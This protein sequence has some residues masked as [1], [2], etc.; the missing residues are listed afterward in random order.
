[1]AIHIQEE[2]ILIPDLQNIEHENLEEKLVLILKSNAKALRRLIASCEKAKRDLSVITQ[3]IVD[4]DALMD[5]EELNVV[6][7]RSK[8]QDLCMDLFKKYIP[9]ENVIKDSKISKNQIDK[10][11]LLIGSTLVPKIQKMAQEF[12]KEKNK[13]KY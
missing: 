1:M 9:L 10:V 4:I 5:G 8:F 13:K 11:V 7:A 6:I 12:F 3:Y 2:N